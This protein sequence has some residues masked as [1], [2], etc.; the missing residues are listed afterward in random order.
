[1]ELRRSPDVNVRLCALSA[2]LYRQA[3]NST[4]V[5]LKKRPPLFCL[6]RMYDEDEAA[7]KGD[8]LEYSTKHGVRTVCVDQRFHC[9]PVVIP[10]QTFWQALFYSYNCQRLPNTNPLL[11]LLIRLWCLLP[12]PLGPRRPW[13]PNQLTDTTGCSSCSSSSS[14]STSSWDQ[15]LSYPQCGRMDAVT[16]DSA[17]LVSSSS[18]YLYNPM[19]DASLLRDMTQTR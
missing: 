9:Y 18:S 5:N 19:T 12:A 17:T 7:D 1:M 8:S 11:V 14:S 4:T 2:W 10:N 13:D 16:P 3:I 6:I 15:L